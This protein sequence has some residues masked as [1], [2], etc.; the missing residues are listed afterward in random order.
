M[1]YHRDQDVSTRLVVEPV[2]DKNERENADEEIDAVNPTR[3]DDVA[4]VVI[5]NG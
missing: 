5:V 1:K 4:V 2:H 3:L